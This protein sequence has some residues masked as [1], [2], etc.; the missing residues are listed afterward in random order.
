MNNLQELTEILV[1]L[2]FPLN[3]NR[4][5][6]FKKGDICYPGF[7]CGMVR[8]FMKG[9]NIYCI[10]KLTNKD[11]YNLSY[12]K[13]IKLAN[14]FIPDFRFTTIQFNKNYQIQKHIDGYNTGISYIIGLGDY[15]GGELLVYFD[16]KD[17]PPTP[18]DIKGKFYT[19]DGSKYYHEVADFTGNRITLVYYNCLPEDISGY[20]INGVKQ[21]EG[22]KSINYQH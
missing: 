22:T 16:G 12:I 5:K 4:K 3:H 2:K 21:P 17:K 10:S 1:W 13:A 11:K 19:F 6:I 14:D 18:I 20:T 9:T 8:D 15:T 7:V